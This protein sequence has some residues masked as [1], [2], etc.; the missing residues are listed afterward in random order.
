MSARLPQ[1]LAGRH[2]D[3]RLFLRTAATGLPLA[4]ALG[5]RFGWTY[6]ADETASSAN[7]VSY[8]DLLVREQEP[9][10]L[11]SPFPRLDSW[12][13]PNDKF[14]IRCHF[15]IPKLEVNDWRLKV[16]GAVERPLDLTYDDL[17]K[18]PSRSA[19]V[20]LEC[21]GNGRAF[22]TPKAKGVQW[23]LGAVSNAEW[24]G[25]SLVAVLERAGLRD[26]AVEVILEGT[27]SGEIKADPKPPGKIHFARSL[28]LEKA[29]KPE[30]LLAYR[31]NGEPLPV[32]HGF[33]LRAV[34]PDWY[35]MASIK[36]LRR[37]VVTEQPFTGFFQSIDYSY[38]ERR[39]GLPSVVPITEL[40][41]KAEIAKPAQDEVLKANTR[42]RVHGA[43]WTGNSSVAKVEVS[44][45]QGQTWAEAKLL[46]KPR[47]AT[48]RQWEYNWQTPAQPGHYHVMAR[49]TDE[50]GRVQPL[51]RDPDRRNYMISHV[52]PVAV[53]VR[54]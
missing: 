28:P 17:L 54:A 52:V 7:P 20:L 16:E 22:L 35:G 27:D 23:E 15:T 33:P 5:G 12:I 11:E 42:Y 4:C 44:T 47:A 14:F 18:M 53:E 6:A 1:P 24:T 13:T 39:H 29:R 46:G 37:I 36:W 50:R 26:R 25:V 38:F 2:L 30:V 40:N 19:P 9:P 21:A 8:P 43:A 41:V 45:D 51:E 31:M 32:A 49:A 48:W 3:R 10:N 34:V